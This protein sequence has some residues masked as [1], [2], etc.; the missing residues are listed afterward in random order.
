[1]NL[2]PEEGGL[3]KPSTAR[4]R[5]RK[6]VKQGLGRYLHEPKELLWNLRYIRK[7][8]Q[9]LKER[10]PDVLLV[11]DHLITSSC[12][13]VSRR[14]GLPLVLEMNAPATESILF[15]DG[16]FH[17]PGLAKLLERYK[18]RNSDGVVVVSKSLKEY[19]E[20]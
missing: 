3:D 6:A 4:L 18:L 13:E 11:R 10:Q 1:M 20:D 7:E 9:M 19:L 5:L 15:N 2:A 14:L 17:V 16:Y 12:V 8:I